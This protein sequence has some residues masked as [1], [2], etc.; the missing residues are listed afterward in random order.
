MEEV[1]KR[2]EMYDTVT[3][4][5]LSEL[6]RHTHERTQDLAE[7]ALSVAKMQQEYF[8]TVSL[9]WINLAEEISR[10]ALTEKDAKET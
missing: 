8:E 1:S 3:Q 4:R 9:I 6:E 7:M 10:V 2:T 5:N